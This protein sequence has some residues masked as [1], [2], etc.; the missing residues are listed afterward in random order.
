MSTSAQ[1][2]IKQRLFRLLIGLLI[3]CGIIF[4]LAPLPIEHFGPMNHYVKH[5]EQ[6]DIHPGALYYSDVPSTVEAEFN[7]RDT[8]RYFHDGK[9]KAS[10]RRKAARPDSL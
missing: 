3:L 8:V 1:P 6:N 7:S 10:A 5:A 9:L 4:M 2:G